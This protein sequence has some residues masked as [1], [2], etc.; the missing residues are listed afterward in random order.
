MTKYQLLQ[1]MEQTSK[2]CLQDKNEIDFEGIIIP[3]KSIYEISVIL[4]ETEGN[5]KLSFSKTRLKVVI[6]RIIIIAN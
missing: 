2:M 3:K 4:D 1:Q 6:G 5:V